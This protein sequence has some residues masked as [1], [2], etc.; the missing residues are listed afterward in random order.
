[1]ENEAAAH[2][3]LIVRTSVRQAPTTA[4]PKKMAGVLTE[5]CKLEKFNLFLRGCEY[6]PSQ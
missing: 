2:T 4:N 5:W 6:I 3:C 1:M